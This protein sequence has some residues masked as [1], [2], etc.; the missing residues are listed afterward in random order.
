VPT[1]PDPEPPP[2]VIGY[3]RSRGAYGI[4]GWI[5]DAA[6]P[7]RRVKFEAVIARDDG[8]EV[9]ATGVA[10]QHDAEL[11]TLG[12]GDARYGF[13]IPLPEG[14]GARDAGRVEI[15]P[16]GLDRVLELPRAAPIGYVRRRD[17]AIIEGWAY[18][19]ADPAQRVRVEAVVPRDGAMVV[20][21]TGTADAYDEEVAQLGLGDGC[22]WF[23]LALP[24][25]L[26]PEDVAR[27][28]VRPV[29][30]D[31][32]LSEVL[33]GT[34]P[35]PSVRTPLVAPTGASAPTAKPQPGRYTG[36]IRERSTHH[37]EGWVVN[38]D[39]TSERVAF[40][41][42]L[43][44]G[45]QERVLA[46]GTAG[47]YDRVLFALG[48]EDPVHGFRLLYDAPL[49][50]AESHRVVVRV[51]ETGLVLPDAPTLISEWKPIRYAAMDIVDNCNLRCPFCIY[52][53]TGVNR[54]HLMEDETFDRVM[55]W[56]PFIGS[57]GLWLSCLHEPSMH[58]KLPEMIERIPREFRER[59]QYTT[60][61]ARRMPDRYY[62]VLADSG[63]ANINVSIESRDPAVYERMRKGARHRIFME[64]WEKLLAA[65]AQGSA[66]PK[67]QYIAMA[68]KSN[69]REL[70]A[71]VEWLRNERRAWKVDIRD[72]YDVPSI[73]PEFRAAEFLDR[74]D[75]VWLR[76]QLAHYSPLEVTLCLPPDF[77][78]TQ[79]ETPVAA[80]VAAE[81]AMGETGTAEP[82][83]ASAGAPEAE[84]GVPAGDPVAPA[85]E[86]LDEARRGGMAALQDDPMFAAK[87]A[88]VPGLL[89]A[90][91]Q[92]DGT[93]TLI[94]TVAGNYPYNGGTIATVNLRDIEDP[95]AF[96]M[97][98]FRQQIAA[99]RA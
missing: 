48:F 12:V 47:Q 96:L 85:Q 23:R 33:R 83:Q 35:V 37:L 91:I 88:A 1:P 34:S 21:A 15:R 57:E 36:Y 10:D 49:S 45:G 25:D 40:D 17:G 20:L 64:N 60:N 4:S 82:A 39:D 38:H 22:C 73:P 79:D 3:L 32:V 51:R 9:L 16:E 30:W 66:P 59:I 13:A 2:R 89:E 98:L 72:T 75:W 76:D 41:V 28:L 11:A 68:Y 77:H 71:L 53:Y 54:T 65:F 14:I 18:D 50:E 74:S 19:R 61:L 70:P 8:W 55:R 87:S 31:S 5:Q 93:M 78:L 69:F 92:Y 29:G 80:T 86:P 24:A 62:A 27:V 26:A 56:L 81:D 63:L 99:A 52:D 46:T 90:R 58:P 67:I 44:E 7:D 43:D 95:E 94:T 42:V 97:S 6:R 84:V